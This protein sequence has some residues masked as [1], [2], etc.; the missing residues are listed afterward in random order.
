M[1][2]QKAAEKRENIWN[3]E[4][5]HLLKCWIF[6]WGWK[7]MTNDAV[8]P[9]RAHNSTSSDNSLKNYIFIHKFCGSSFQACFKWWNGRWGFKWGRILPLWSSHGND[10]QKRLEKNKQ[11]TPY[12]P[13]SSINI[14]VELFMVMLFMAE[15][16]SLFSALIKK[17]KRE[18]KFIAKA[19]KL[20]FDDRTGSGRQRC[21]PHSFSPLDSK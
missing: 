15:V 10:W 6:C 20:F 12:T 14:A 8:K 7:V 13:I 16:R 1:M 21:F 4:T 11:V 17:F 2:S 19:S 3:S 9:G 5:K 18:K